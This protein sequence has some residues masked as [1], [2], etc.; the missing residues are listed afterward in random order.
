LNNEKS[1]HANQVVAQEGST[2]KRGR[3]F[4]VT[5]ATLLK[6]HRS[7]QSRMTSFLSNQDNAMISNQNATDFHIH[8]KA[9]QSVSQCSEVE[10]RLEGVV[11]NLEVQNSNS[12][13]NDCIA[14][15]PAEEEQSSGASEGRVIDDFEKELLDDLNEEIMEQL[16]KEAGLMEDSSA[17]DIYLQTIQNRIKEDN[18]KGLS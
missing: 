9:T 11:S 3:S 8:K 12:I 10:C 5:K 17:V 4:G 7:N 13:V 18:K 16:D 1:K 15:E 6:T 2:A 14:N